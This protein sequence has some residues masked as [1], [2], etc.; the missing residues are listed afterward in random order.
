M[1][2]SSVNVLLAIDTSWHDPRPTLTPHGPGSFSP[3]T[4]GAGQ[5]L[6]SVNASKVAQGIGICAS[7]FC[8]SDRAR[9]TI[10][11]KS[12]VVEFRRKFCASKGGLAKIYSTVSLI[13]FPLY[14]SAKIDS[15]MR[16]ILGS[17]RNC[18]EKSE[19]TQDNMWHH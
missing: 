12:I 2:T 8:A 5:H 11:P 14:A 1:R 3:V 6:R 15:L 4:V 18:S 13:S 19:G 7:A 17:E 16:Y 10:V 9:K